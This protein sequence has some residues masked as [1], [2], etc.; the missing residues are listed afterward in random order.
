MLSTSTMQFTHLKLVKT[1][2]ETGKIPATMTWVKGHMNLCVPTN[3][4][5]LGF[6]SVGRR[7]Q[8]GGLITGQ[9]PLNGYSK[10]RRLKN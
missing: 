9:S 7:T 2:A 4:S 1:K 8:S 6:G 3:M 5:G 10:S